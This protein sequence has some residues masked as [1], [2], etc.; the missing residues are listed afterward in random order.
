[1]PRPTAATAGEPTTRLDDDVW[2]KVGAE[3]REILR[4]A[5]DTVPEEARAKAFA[6]TLWLTWVTGYF[7]HEF[8]RKNFFGYT[9]PPEKPGS[10]LSPPDPSSRRAA[11]R[12]P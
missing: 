7:D 9:M 1:M 8:G 6:G 5:H 3:A 4:K 10:T 11:V 2:E 12:P